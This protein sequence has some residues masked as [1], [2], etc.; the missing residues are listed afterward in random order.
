[1]FAAA[2]HSA[3]LSSAETTMARGGGGEVA[4]EEEDGRGKAG[5]E[6]HRSGKS[7]DHAAKQWKEAREGI[8]KIRLPN[9]E[10]DHTVSPGDGHFQRA[11]K[12]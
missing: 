7:I 5:S 12:T 1:M 11:R 8:R 6:K 3:A 9:A 4:I 2:V 10:R